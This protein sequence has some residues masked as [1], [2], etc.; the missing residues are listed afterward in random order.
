MI[1]FPSQLTL[2]I[3]ILLVF[4]LSLHLVGIMKHQTN[5]NKKNKPKLVL[6]W[7][8]FFQEVNYIK[9]LNKMKCD[10][11]NCVFT[12]DKKLLKESDA[13]IFHHRDLNPRNIPQRPN[14]EQIWISLNLES[15]VHTPRN[16]YYLNGQVNWTISYRHDADIVALPKLVNRTMPYRI[17]KNYTLNK[18]KPIVW[19]VSHCSTPGK[20]EDFVKHLHDSIPIDIYGTC[21]HL[22]C[23]PKMSDKCYHLMSRYYF[24]LSFENSICDDYVTEKF[25]NILDYDIIPIVFGGANYSRH[26]PYSG[27]IDALS[28]QSPRHLSEYLAHLIKHPEEYNKFFEWKKDYQFS[29]EYFGCQICRKLNDKQTNP[30]TWKNLSQW[31]FSSL[32]KKWTQ[33]DL[34]PSDYVYN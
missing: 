22:K 5:L 1:M 13:V 18:D 21:G 9:P 19:F 27:Y 14:F 6:L 7:T 10:H 24:Y 3:I 8:P 25:F 12:S 28:F 33:T 16:F 20:R 30:K 15:P 17:K 26:L 31:W 2:L 11:T 34:V 29:E 23:T 32:C 4:F